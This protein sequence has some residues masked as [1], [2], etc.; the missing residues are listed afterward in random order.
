[1]TVTGP[2][3]I[4]LQ[5]RD[6]ERAA[7]FYEQRLGLRRTPASP[8]GAIV[9]ATTPVA[10]AVREPLPGVDLEA[11]RPGLGVALWLHSTDAQAVHDALAEAGVP[12]ATPP[13]DG[14]FGRTF[15]FTD[16]DGYA[17]TIHDKP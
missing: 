17:V 11:G 3:F 15:T 14:P 1:M 4:A 12:I 10:F 5:V 7:T 8:P 13:S 6:L 16:P 2:D 9:F